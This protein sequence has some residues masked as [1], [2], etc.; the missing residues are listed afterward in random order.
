ML[1]AKFLLAFVGGASVGVSF[2]AVLHGVHTLRPLFLLGSWLL[3]VIGLFAVVY[4]P[5]EDAHAEADE[6]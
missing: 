1:F 2:Y 6:A 4:A 5:K 3:C